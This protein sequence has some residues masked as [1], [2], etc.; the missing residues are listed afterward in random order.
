M[1]QRPQGLGQAVQHGDQE[2]RIRQDTFFRDRSTRFGHAYGTQQQ[3]M[4]GLRWRISAY[5]E[6]TGRNLRKLLTSHRK[7]LVSNKQSQR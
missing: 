5:C 1:P 6:D 3:P 7:P 4:D 2:Q